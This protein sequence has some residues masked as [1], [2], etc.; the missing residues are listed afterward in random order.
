MRGQVERLAGIGCTHREI[1][2]VVGL[3]EKTVRKYYS[4]V[5][6]EGADKGKASLRRQ[7]LKAA[8]EGNATMLVWLGKTWLEQKE[9]VVNEHGGIG[10]GPVQVALT[11]AIAAR[12]AR[13]GHSDDEDAE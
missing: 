13:L 10:G 5:I 1:A 7:Q 4:D 12:N 6:A 9:T 11:D 3:D 2:S 8:N